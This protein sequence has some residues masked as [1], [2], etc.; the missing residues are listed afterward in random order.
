M[1]S[2]GLMVAVIANVAKNPFRV[3]S[4]LKAVSKFLCLVS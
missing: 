4:S 2:G 3:L 1:P